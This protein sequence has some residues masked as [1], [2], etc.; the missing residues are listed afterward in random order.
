MNEEQD[1][2]Y[3]EDEAVKF[4]QNFLPQE[5]KG[6][7]SD[8]DINY[9]ID[10]VYEFYESKGFLDDEDEEVDED[11]DVFVEINEDELI[12][13][14]TKNARKDMVGKFTADEIAFVVEGELEYCNSIQLFEE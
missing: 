9:L 7:F 5:L 4:V 8:D 14:V 6:K 1:L 3:D 11:E 13:Y 12:Q 2:I 10:V